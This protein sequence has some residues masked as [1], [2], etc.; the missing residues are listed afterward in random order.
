MSAWIS[1]ETP[2]KKMGL[3]LIYCRYSCKRKFEVSFAYR[4]GY[5]KNPFWL[6]L[7]EWHD[8]KEITHWMPLPEPPEQ[9]SRDE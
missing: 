4:A 2:P 5:S 3:V 9:C 8:I 7:N 6:P 1:I